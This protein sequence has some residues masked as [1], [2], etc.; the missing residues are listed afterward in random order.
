[1][2]TTRDGGQFRAQASISDRN[3]HQPF[4]ARVR[5]VRFASSGFPGC[6][7]E[8]SDDQ[9][10]MHASG[11]AAEQNATNEGQW[12]AVAKGNGHASVKR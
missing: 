6:L 10:G 9:G 11:T 7:P 8:A 2:P 5:S 12:A 1:M 3:R 4:L